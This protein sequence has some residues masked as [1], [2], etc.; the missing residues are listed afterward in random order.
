M[1]HLHRYMG[2]WITGGLT[3]TTEDISTPHKQDDTY[4]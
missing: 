4:S 3:E 2:I 1:G